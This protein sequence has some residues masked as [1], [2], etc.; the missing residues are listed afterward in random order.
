[1]QE[2]KVTII[3]PVYNGEQYIERCI[4]SI[5]SQSFVDYE[6]I[7]I[8]DGSLDNTTQLIEDIVGNASNWTIVNRPNQ[9]VASARNLGLEVA[10][11]KYIVFVDSDDFLEMSYLELLYDNIVRTNSDLACC[12]YFDH[13]E[14]GV[15]VHNN[16][17]ER[18]SDIV[19]TKEAFL[20][21]LMGTG[22]V[23]WDKM[24]RREV[25]NRNNLRMSSEIY[26]FEDSLFVI[27]YLASIE[28]ISFLNNALYNYNRLNEGSFTRKIDVSWLDN[29]VQYNKLLMGKSLSLGVD[30]TEI[31]K[32]VK[33]NLWSFV[34]NTLSYEKLRREDWMDR[35]NSFKII[36]ENSELNGL[37]NDIELK[38][39]HRIFYR[40][41]RKRNFLFLS[42]FTWFI[43]IFRSVK[44]TFRL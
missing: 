44:N 35:I 30:D 17:K 19:E 34:Y 39:P 9:G 24:F 4:H 7:V 22:G 14:N 29:V 13:S 16:Y 32:H 41:Y 27:D 11:G 23:L 15:I 8:N 21:F 3:L 1:M 12:T 28:S 42:I 6:V 40:F 36:T 25:I 20:L 2:P 31:R 33:K 26:Y 18:R 10:L 43:W 5:V 37:L 38:L